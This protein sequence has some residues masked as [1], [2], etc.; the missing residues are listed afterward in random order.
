MHVES[1]VALFVDIS[2]ELI[3]FVLSLRKSKGLSWGCWRARVLT[4]LRFNI[5][6]ISSAM[7]ILFSKVMLKCYFAVMRAKKQGMDISCKEEWNVEKGEEKQGWKW[8]PPKL[9]GDSLGGSSTSQKLHLA[10]P[11]KRQTRRENGYFNN[12]PNGSVILNLIT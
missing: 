12:S 2:V 1:W 6:S 4:H 10:R 5:Q 9:L 8:H 7:L 3:D 11:W